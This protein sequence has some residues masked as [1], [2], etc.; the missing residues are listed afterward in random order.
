MSCQNTED[1]TGFK[2]RLLFDLTS[3]RFCYK[4]TEG[5][6]NTHLLIKNAD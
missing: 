4:E 2:A 6:P 5:L 3:L 1:G